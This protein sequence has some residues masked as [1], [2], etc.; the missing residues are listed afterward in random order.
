[1]RHVV[2]PVIIFSFMM[3]ITGCN[4]TNSTITIPENYDTWTRLNRE[5]LDYPIPGH[6]SNYRI[7]YINEKGLGL[8]VSEDNNRK[9]TFPEGTIIAKSVY[10]GLNPAADARPVM[11]TSMIKDPDHPNARGGW[12]WVMKDLNAGKTQIIEETFCYTCHA[13]ANEAH[14]Y[15]DGNPQEEFRDFVFFAASQP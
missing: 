11:V 10:E 5:E 13:A 9:Y 7:I 1:M 12:V 15:A 3:L 14:P 2:I 6:E 8:T 4:E